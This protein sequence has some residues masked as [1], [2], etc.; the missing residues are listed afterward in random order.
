MSRAF[1]LLN[2]DDDVVVAARDL[3]AGEQLELPQA[4]VVLVESVGL[5][6]KVSIRT[7]AQGQPVRKYG[8][9]IGFA[10]RDIDPGSHVHSH[11][12][13]NGDAVGDPRPC[14]EVP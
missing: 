13:I 4:T 2:P 12:V 11:N 3:L 6:H 9:V 8:Q 5:G 1:V 10:T 7:I 14:T